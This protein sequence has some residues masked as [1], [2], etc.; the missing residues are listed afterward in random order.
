MS[1][2]T[3]SATQVG[4]KTSAR[5]P[6]LIVGTSDMQISEV[7][8]ESTVATSSTV[9]LRKFTTTGTAGTAITAIIWDD[10]GVAPGASGSH[11]PSTDHTLTTGNLRTSHL[12][13]AV[14]GGVIWTFDPPLRIRGGSGDGVTITL[15]SGT[16]Q[17]INFYIDWEE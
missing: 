17:I 5:G 8:V 13:A 1:K 7:G 10:D 4:A 15:P 9:A 12:P 11:V 2:F 3:V 6:T 16:D 14:G